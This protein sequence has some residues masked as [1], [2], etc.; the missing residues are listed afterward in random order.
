MKK[1]YESQL[2]VICHNGSDVIHPSEVKPGT[3]LATGQLYVEEF[4]SEEE[5]KTRL[6]ELG[7]DLSKLEEDP[8]K[9]TPEPAEKSISL[10]NL[11]KGDK[12][13]T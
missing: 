7:F 11:L 13:S 12:P 6:T 2:F 3:Y 4:S 8:D 10:K 9:E 1:L 5:W